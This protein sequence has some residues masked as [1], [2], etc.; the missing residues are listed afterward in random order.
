MKNSKLY[1]N[2]NILLTNKIEKLW[3]NR[4]WGTE[5]KKK[6]IGTCPETSAFEKGPLYRVYF[7]GSLCLQF[8]L[9]AALRLISPTTPALKL[10]RLIKMCAL[11][12]FLSASG[13]DDTQ[14]GPNG[15]TGAEQPRE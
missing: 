1:F 13:S 9:T 12:L 4:V 8:V 6:K 7:G 2:T 3:Q 14:W 10:C 11:A 15:R 5:K